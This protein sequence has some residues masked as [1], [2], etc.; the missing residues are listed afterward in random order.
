MH[1]MQC[2]IEGKEHEIYMFYV[3][4]HV[5]NMNSNEMNLIHLM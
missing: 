1:K 5:T 4:K 2:K 3:R